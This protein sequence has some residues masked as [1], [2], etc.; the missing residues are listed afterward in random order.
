MAGRGG[1]ISQ[2]NIQ[3]T[4]SPTV[5]Q[6]VAHKVLRSL[7]R[8]HRNIEGV[9]LCSAVIRHSVVS[10]SLQPHGAAAHQAPL[11]TGFPRQEYWNGLPFPPLG[12]L[13]DPRI[14][15]MSLVSCIAGKLFTC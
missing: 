10:N 8:G 4:S 15:L 1:I 2:E 7:K 14:K 5:A 3:F 9:C 11:S 12:D 6:V 13:P